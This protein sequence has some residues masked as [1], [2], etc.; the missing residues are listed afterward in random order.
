[1]PPIQYVGSCQQL[2]EKG[3]CL[4]TL[5]GEGQSI[6][7]FM[8]GSFAQRTNSS[9]LQGLHCAAACLHFSSCL[10]G[11]NTVLR[12]NVSWPIFL[13]NLNHT[14]VAAFSE[15]STVF[16]LEIGFLR[17][18]PHGSSAPSLLKP[19]QTGAGDLILLLGG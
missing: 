18:M 14:I 15:M 13:T 11:A 10:S 12:Y 1:M 19:V 2:H 7:S 8:Q 9:T 17:G 4:L 3:D 16:C 5:T 6:L